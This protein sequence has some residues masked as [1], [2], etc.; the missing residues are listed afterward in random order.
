MLKDTHIILSP[1]QVDRA[2]KEAKRWVSVDRQGKERFGFNT[3]R[4][5][6]ET[7]LEGIA[8]QIAAASFFGVADNIHS[9]RPWDIDIN[10]QL[11]NV[12]WIQPGGRALVKP[13]DIGLSE[14]APRDA[15]PAKWFLFLEGTLPVYDMKGF[16]LS[17]MAAQKKFL[18]NPGYK[19]CY[20]ITLDDPVVWTDFDFF[21]R[22]DILKETARRVGEY[23]QNW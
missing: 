17:C 13:V 23:L 5:D 2:Q 14:N 12:K 22:P 10:G 20:A 9:R 11:I 7:D 21:Y 19:V 3:K 18:W 15:R 1:E 16:T 6:Y 8:A 4:P